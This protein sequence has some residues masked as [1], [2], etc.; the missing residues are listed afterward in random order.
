MARNPAT[1]PRRPMEQLLLNQ[2]RNRARPTATPA[3][4]PLA[5]ASPWPQTLSLTDQI[6]REPVRARLV[7]PAPAPPLL[8]KASPWPQTPSQTD[9]IIREPV[10]ARLL[11][12]APPPL[13]G[14]QRSTRARRATPARDVGRRRAL[15]GFLRWAVVLPKAS[16]VPKMRLV[17]FWAD[18]TRPSDRR[19]RVAYLGPWSD[20]W[21]LA[22]SQRQPGLAG[23]PASLGASVRNSRRRCSDLSQ[24]LLLVVRSRSASSVRPHWVTG[25]P[26]WALDWGR[27][28]PNPPPEVSSEQLEQRRA[29]WRDNRRAVGTWSPAGTGRSGNRT[30]GRLVGRGLARLAV[31]V[32]GM[33]RRRSE[34]AA[35][36]PGSCSRSSG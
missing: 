28:L 11:A 3:P 21:G 1:K 8:A 20:S 12:P 15:A 18:R 34:P 31:I 5:K 9:Q 35:W 10:R 36:T 22:S 25:L 26:F 19:R 27:T 23:R 14:A 6:I 30:S 33:V 2:H 7:A 17:R 29:W 4:P 16:V 24:K 32:L 13:E